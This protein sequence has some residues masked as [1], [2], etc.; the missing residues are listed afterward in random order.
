MCES[1]FIR[2]GPNAN[3]RPARTDASRR[4]V[5]L[6]ASAY[7]ERPHQ[8][9][10]SR[11]TTLY[12]ASGLPVSHWTGAVTGSRPI[13]SSDSAMESVVG[14]NIGAF[15]HADV[16]GTRWALHHMSQVL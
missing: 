6:M 5:R 13:S 2:Y 15:H 16:S 1:W 12:A 7:I 14:K 11:K 3:T 8:T 9:N 4:P 10:D